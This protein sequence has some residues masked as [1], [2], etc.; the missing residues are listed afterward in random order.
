[1]GSFKCWIAVLSVALLG[2]CQNMEDG[3]TD[4]PQSASSVSS[5]ET[6]AVVQ[7]VDLESRQVLLETESGRLT[8]IVAG[9]EV[10]NLAQIEPGDIVRA[11]HEQSVAVQMVER[12]QG[13]TDTQAVVAVGR[14]AEGRSRC[15]CGGDHL[16]RWRTG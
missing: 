5:V 1:M 2:A 14:A 6:N 3:S 15:R 11:V 7:L 4:A 16:R 8:T 12:G 9:P 10:R 13:T